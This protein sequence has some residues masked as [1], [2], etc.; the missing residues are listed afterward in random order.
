[1]ETRCLHTKVGNIDGRSNK[2]WDNIFSLGLQAMGRACI[3]ICFQNYSSL[4][5]VEIIVYFE[6]SIGLCLIANVKKYR[7]I[8]YVGRHGVQFGVCLPNL[9]SITY[10]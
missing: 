4:N 9:R 8:A 10:A 6:N 7:M 3:K 1:M 2:W 5:G